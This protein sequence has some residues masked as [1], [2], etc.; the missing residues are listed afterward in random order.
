MESEQLNALVRWA[1]S[2]SELARQQG[3]V[4]PAINESSS[5]A[6][7]IGWAKAVEAAAG[8]YLAVPPVPSEQDPAAFLAWARSI[9]GMVRGF[10]VVLPP[11]PS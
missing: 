5:F 11:L 1:R 10:G 8:P 2:L 9:D 7:L 4:L 3:L 6:E